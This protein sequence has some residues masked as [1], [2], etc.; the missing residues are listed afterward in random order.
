MEQVNK[1]KLMAI[2]DDQPEEIKASFETMRRIAK[3]YGGLPE[4]LLEEDG[5]QLDYAMIA[6]IYW[7][8]VQQDEPA[9][10]EEEIMAKINMGNAHKIID[11][12]NTAITPTIPEELLL[13]QE[14]E[15]E[16]KEEE[17]DSKVEGGKNP[18]NSIPKAKK[19]ST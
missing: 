12:I 5:K 19:P 8:L 6:K 2:F 14:A 16:G 10:T 13:M 3:E 11:I 18:K 15:D 17:A 1:S 4:S 7:F 9:R